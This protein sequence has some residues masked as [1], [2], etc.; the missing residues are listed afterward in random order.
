MAQYQINVRLITPSLYS[1]LFFNCRGGWSRT[2]QY[3]DMNLALHQ[4][5]P[6]I[7]GMD[8]F[9]ELIAMIRASILS[10]G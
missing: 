8:L 7:L 2:T 9:T 5:S 3:K 6:Q 4:Q 1:L 10:S